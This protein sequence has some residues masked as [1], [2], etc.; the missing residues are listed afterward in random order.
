MRLVQIGDKFAIVRGIF[1]KEYMDMTSNW[2]CDSHSDGWWWITPSTIRRYSY[3]PTK[4]YAL[5][6]LAE[7]RAAKLK[8]KLKNT[9]KTI[10]WWV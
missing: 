4:E 3:A 5:E 10:E 2:Y 1:F 8:H 6:R 7:Y 9:T